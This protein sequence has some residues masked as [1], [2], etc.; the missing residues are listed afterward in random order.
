MPDWNACQ[1][2][3]AA[4]AGGSNSGCSYLGVDVRPGREEQP[5]HLEEAAEC[6]LVQG[7]LA[8][9]VL[10]DRGLRLGQSAGTTLSPCPIGTPANPSGGLQQGGS[11]FGSVTLALTSAPDWRSSRATSSWPLSAA[12]CRAVQPYESCANRAETVSLC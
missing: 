6:G 4:A 11:H 12:Q 7:R 3:R 10:R 5:D 9:L 8:V 2:G 1:P